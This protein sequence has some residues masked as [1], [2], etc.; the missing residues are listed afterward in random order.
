MKLKTL[1]SS[2]SGNCHILTSNSGKHLIIEAGIPVPEIKKGVDFDIENIEA[3]IAGHVHQD[4]S[5]SCEKLKKMGLTVW[6]PYLD[7][8][9]PNQKTRFGEFEVRCFGLPHNGVENRGFIIKADDTT[10]CYMCD[11]E[12]CPFNLESQNI[13]VLMVECN[14]MEELVNEQAENFKHK[15]LGHCSLDT[16]IGIIKANLKHLRT[17]ELLHMSN[18]G[19][20]DREKAMERI[21]AEIPPYIEV[22]YA[23]KDLE[24]I[25]D[26]CPF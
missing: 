25:L 8:E 9:H 3:V 12:L 19:S 16:C 24:I 6:Q 1:S 22:V 21:K 10:V 17:V 18:S 15:V 11:M 5:V 14:Y 23:A 4:H 26:E 7:T 13:N 2:S 20:F